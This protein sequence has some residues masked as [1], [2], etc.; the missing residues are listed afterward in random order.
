MH[1]AA[2]AQIE[3]ELLLHLAL[4]ASRT[5]LRLNHGASALPCSARHLSARGGDLVLDQLDSRRV[6]HHLP[7]VLRDPDVA[8]V[9]RLARGER[10]RGRDAC[11][12]DV[13]ADFGAAWSI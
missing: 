13:P 8:A 3:A 9:L 1:V 11:M 6:A 5:V 2:L 4:G 12:V 10:V 7:V